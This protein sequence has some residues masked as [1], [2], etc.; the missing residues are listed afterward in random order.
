MDGWAVH[1]T[2]PLWLLFTEDK[3][4]QLQ[5]ARLTDMKVVRWRTGD[6]RYCIP[7]ELP[8]GVEYDAALDSVVA[9]LKRIAEQLMDSGG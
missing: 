8:T 4:K 1:G 9:S 3:H 2:T 7:I 6:W 5:D